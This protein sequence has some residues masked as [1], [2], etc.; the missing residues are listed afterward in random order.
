MKIYNLYILFIIVGV[1]LNTK[2]LSQNV[3][4]DVE[5]ELS[6]P[7]ERGTLDVSSHNGT[8]E[9]EGYDGQE[10]LV[11]IQADGDD[12]D[13]EYNGNKGGL[14][15]ITMN[16]IDVDIYEEDNYVSVSAQQNRT[17]FKI[18]VPRNFDLKVK[19]H[20]NGLVEVSDVD[21]QMEIISHHGAIHL[22]DV[23]G[24]LVADT[25]H[26][27][28]TANFLSITDKPMAFSTYHGDVDIT[29][30]ASTNFDAKIKS[31]KGDIYTDFD[32][33]MNPISTERNT[34]KGKNKSKS[35]TKIKIGGWV[36]GQFGSGGNEYLF[37]TYHG[38]V[39]I[40]KL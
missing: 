38:D 34:S 25:H 3:N 31:G 8:I 1:L 33:N 11:T 19:A 32:V 28:I 9:I 22:T 4:E 17:D 27:E 40:R 20:H 10:V 36:T 6:S 26:G 29:F 37:N 24:S 14:K 12:D 39:I 35:K 5:V 23:S 30:P 16:S 2:A 7:G 13:N 15:R 18:K 21:G